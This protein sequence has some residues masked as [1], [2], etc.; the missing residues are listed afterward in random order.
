MQKVN[1]IHLNPVRAGLVE[2]ALIIEVVWLS[3]SLLAKKY[4]PKPIERHIS[5]TTH[6]CDN[7]IILGERH[8]EKNFDQTG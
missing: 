4:S 7:L 5:E 8:A 1:Y 2:R 6:N 3:R